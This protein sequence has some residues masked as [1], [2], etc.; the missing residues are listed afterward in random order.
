MLIIGIGNFKI[1]EIKIKLVKYDSILFLIVT[2]VF[3]D[4][5]DSFVSFDFLGASIVV[6]TSVRAFRFSKSRFFTVV[7]VGLGL[8]TIETVLSYRS[9]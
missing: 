3:F 1:R 6:G 8:S 2:Y 7:V 5:L 9:A 4:S